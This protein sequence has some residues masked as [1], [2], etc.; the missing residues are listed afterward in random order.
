MMKRNGKLLFGLALMALSMSASLAAAEDTAGKF[1][2]SQPVHWGD[3]LLP[4]GDYTCAVENRGPSRV[5]F[6]RGAEG[7]PSYLFA[8]FSTSETALSDQNHLTLAVRG[9]ERFVQAL[10]LGTLGET[11]YFTVPKEKAPAEQIASTGAASSL[12]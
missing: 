7:K 3:A 9:D 5:V 4:A 2:L 10:A 11:V 8:A 12:R 6:V 1:T